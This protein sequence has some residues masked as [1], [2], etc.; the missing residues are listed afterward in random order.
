M[1][2]RI[3]LPVVWA[4]CLFSCGCESEYGALHRLADIIDSG[5]ESPENA[6]WLKDL[7]HFIDHESAFVRS[8]AVRAIGEIY[9]GTEDERLASLCVTILADKLDDYEETIVAQCAARALI[10]IGLPHGHPETRVIETKLRNAAKDLIHY[11]A[12]WY[13]MDALSLIDN[14]SDETRDVLIECLNS[15]AESD[16]QIWK[17]SVRKHAAAAL[18]G[19]GSRA[20]VALPDLKKALADTSDRSWARRVI[21]EA[22]ETIEACCEEEVGSSSSGS[23]RR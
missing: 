18:A 13:A 3:R 23:E 19:F 14:P 10:K 17:D 12:A 15:V 21:T 11:G 9:G 4:V 20:A 6:A 16:Y 1:P 8:S 7:L 2:N 22:I 5:Q